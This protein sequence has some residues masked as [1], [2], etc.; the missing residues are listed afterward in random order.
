[1][2]LTHL[3]QRLRLPTDIIDTA[4]QFRSSPDGPC[5]T[6]RAVAVLQRPEDDFIIGE[7]LGKGAFGVVNLGVSKETGQRFA[8]KTMIRS[9]TRPEFLKNELEVLRLIARDHPHVV[10]FNGAYELEDEVT[11]VMEL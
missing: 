11:I 1:M 5:A 10:G 9:K 4:S 7:A 3:T 2:W 6:L 8:L